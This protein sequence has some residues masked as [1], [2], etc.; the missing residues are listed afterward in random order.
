M[1]IN[2]DCAALDKPDI[3]TIVDVLR[4][5]VD[6]LTAAQENNFQDLTEDDYEYY[7]LIINACKLLIDP[8]QR[9]QGT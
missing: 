6:E 5:V 8:D 4:E 3:E 2:N 1:E 7:E 9:S